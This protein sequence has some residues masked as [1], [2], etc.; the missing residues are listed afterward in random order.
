MYRPQYI[1]TELSFMKM[2]RGIKSSLINLFSV[3]FVFQILVILFIEIISYFQP[4]SSLNILR[5]RGLSSFAWDMWLMVFLL[6]FF[7]VGCSTLNKIKVLPLY[8]LTIYPAILVMFSII[9]DVSALQ[10]IVFSLLSCAVV[11]QINYQRIKEQV[12][13]KV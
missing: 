1:E 13:A 5:P 2:K 12:Y 4:T 11:L 8:S 7:L 6:S 9:R 3:Q 10:I